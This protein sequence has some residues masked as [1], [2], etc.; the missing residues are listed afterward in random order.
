MASE[1]DAGMRVT[2]DE[3]ICS[4]TLQTKERDDSQAVPVLR[5]QWQLTHL[6][7]S[8]QCPSFMFMP[9]FPPSSLADLGNWG[10]VVLILEGAS[11]PPAGGAD[12]SPG[13]AAGGGS[14]SLEPLLLTLG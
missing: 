11:E 2:K 4:D 14:T 1:K 8:Q 9:R 13:A 7:Y 6:F 12:E 5:A 3:L 10:A